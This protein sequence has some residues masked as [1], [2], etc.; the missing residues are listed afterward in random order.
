MVLDPISKNE[1]NKELLYFHI[2]GSGLT[3]N[4]GEI[5][6]IKNLVD[7]PWMMNFIHF[8]DANT[9]EFGFIYNKVRKGDRPGVDNFDLSY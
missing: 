8:G 1:Y 5:I 7:V 9:T 4:F 6:L 2:I 3:M